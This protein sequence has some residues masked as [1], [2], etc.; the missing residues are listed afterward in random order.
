MQIPKT[1]KEI[2][3]ILDITGYYWK[4]IKHY[5]KVVQSIT[6]YL[7]KDQSIRL[8][9]DE[10]VGALEKLKVLLTPAPILKHPD[11]IQ[12]FKLTTD[13]RN[14]AIGAVFSQNGYPVSY[15]S[16]TLNEREKGYAT[17]ENEMLAIVWAIYR[18]IPN[19][20]RD[21]IK[22]LKEKISHQNC[23]AGY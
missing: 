21:Y 4:S 12:R 7:K 11:F 16:R 8:N 22:N 23:N 2:K 3:S 15:N 5:T 6:K 9:I 13:A 17:I 14:Y 19:Q 20:L 18:P 10:Y 1:R